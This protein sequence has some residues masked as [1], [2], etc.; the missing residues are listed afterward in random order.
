MVVQAAKFL[1]RPDLASSFSSARREALD[2]GCG[3]GRNSLY[4]AE[5]GWRVTAVDV[6]P[7]ALE[8]IAHANIARV[9][10]DLEAGEFTIEPESFDLIVDVF[11]LQRNL[12]PAIRRGLRIG[13]IFAA[14]LPM[15]DPD[16]PPMNREYL[17]ESGELA[18]LF[19]DWETLLSE[20]AAPP[21]H[22]RKSAR[23]IARKTA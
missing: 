1:A 12:F 6:S 10:A 8:G 5:R 11:Y 17:V 2:L 14:E 3:L 22:G 9:C 20:E 4:L 15:V 18:A 23:F 19:A 7:V 16:A 21:E 13:G